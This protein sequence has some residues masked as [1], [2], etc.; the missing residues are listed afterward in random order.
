MEGMKI[1]AKIET[2]GFRPSEIRPRKM[3]TVLQDNLLE[4][5]ND[6]CEISNKIIPDLN[7]FWKKTDPDDEENKSEK[8]DMDDVERRMWDLKDQLQAL[9][10]DCFMR[11]ALDECAFRANELHPDSYLSGFVT[12]NVDG[13]P[14]FAARIKQHPEMTMHFVFESK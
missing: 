6:Y 7:E 2:V 12:Q 10:Y 13:D 4:L 1:D 3:W 11:N 9:R 5:Y 14:V 8:D